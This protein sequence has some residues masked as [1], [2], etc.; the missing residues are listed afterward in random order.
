MRQIGFDRVRSMFPGGDALL[1]VPPFSGFERP[2]LGLHVLQAVAR[3]AGFKVDIL[4]ANVHFAAAY[5]ENPYTDICY[6]PTGILS[7][8]KFFAPIAFPGKVKPFY[9]PEILGFALEWVNNLA[10]FVAEL[11]YPIVGCNTMFEQLNCSVAIL[12]RIK[13]IQPETVTILG[14]AQCEDEM[15]EGILSL[16]KGIDH[17]FQGES[18]ANFVAFLRSFR[19]GKQDL[20]PLIQGS[21]LQDMEGLP[22]VDYTSFFDQFEAMCPESEILKSNMF[23]LPL[24]GSRGCWWGQKHHC[25]FC[26]INGNGMGYRK[27]TATKMFGEIE[28]HASVSG[29]QNI[30]MVDNIMPHEYF[31]TLLPD[32]ADSSFQLRI[33]YEQK[34]NLTARR[35]EAISK[36]GITIIQPGIESLSDDLLVMMKKGVKSWQNINALRHARMYDVHVNWNLLHSFPGDKAQH[37]TNMEKLIPKIHH[38]CPPSGLNKLSVDRFSPYFDNADQYGVTNIRPMRAYFDIFPKDT[39]F[40]KIAY[41]FLADYESEALNVPKLLDPLESLLDDWIEAWEAQTAPPVLTVAKLGANSFLVTDT[42]KL[43]KKNFQFVDEATALTMLFGSLGPETTKMDFCIDNE[44]CVQTGDVI[45][46]LAVTN[47]SLFKEL[48]GGSST[49]RPQKALHSVN[50]Q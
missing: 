22:D 16:G 5:G 30:L 48:C 45:A 14:G 43:A 23:W 46:P 17:I 37:Y 18:E 15:A 35:M 36:A 20:R 21:P 13:K 31:D 10:D 26:G 38:L 6:A 41:H 19:A 11:P 49:E 40:Q 8:E 44:F 9:K 25:T 24:E 7:G 12:D 4:N 50:A 47:A 33:F 28:K 42:R 2:S 39:E 27:K 29:V 1:I 32:L 3:A 34:A